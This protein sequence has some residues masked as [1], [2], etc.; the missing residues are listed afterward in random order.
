MQEPHKKGV[1]NH[2]GPESCAN[3]REV[4]GE[5]L[6][7]EHAGQPSSSEITTSACRPRPDRGKATPTVPLGEGL[8]GA[9]ESETLCMRGRSR[10]ENRETSGTPASVGRG[11]VGEGRKPHARRARPRGVGRS[12]S[13]NEADE[14]GWPVGSGGVRGGKGIDQGECLLRRPRAGH[15]AGQSGSF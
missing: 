6:T 2:L 11:T 10:R 5:A 12:R 14:Q 13:S 8:P 1:A 7:G 15:S 4:V 9:A 3:G